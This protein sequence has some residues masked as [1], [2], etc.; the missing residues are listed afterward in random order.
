MGLM[1]CVAAN[2]EE[3]VNIALRLANDRDW[4]DDVRGRLVN[5]RT[6]L[7]ENRGV[8]RELEEFLPAALRRAV[9]GNTGHI[10]PRIIP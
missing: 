7:L 10:E 4:R 3:Y 9:E 1:D 5:A 2:R 6:V 8:I